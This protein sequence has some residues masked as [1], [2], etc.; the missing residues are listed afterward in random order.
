MGTLLSNLTLIIPEN[1]YIKDPQS[2]KLGR[3]ILEYSIQIIRKEGLE[4]FTFKKLAEEISS[5]ESS[6]YRYFENKHMLMLYLISWYW[7]WLEYKLVF[8]INNIEC[9]EKVLKR[10][11]CAITETPRKDKT[12]GFINEEELHHIIVQESA[13]AFHTIDVDEENKNG[14]F[15]IYRRLVKR[16]GGIIAD[17]NSEYNYPL[18]LANTVL[19][20]AL[21]QNFLHQH[22]K[23]LS[24]FKETDEEPFTQFFQHLTFKS[25][26]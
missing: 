10:A 1:I 22:F 6:V 25:L 20:G 5:N 11:I 2:S 24:D 8:R 18:T 19:Q 13:K 21:N 16:L 23:Q 9:K 4:K 12:F 17:Y 7:A 15:V 26:S 14:Y 3:R